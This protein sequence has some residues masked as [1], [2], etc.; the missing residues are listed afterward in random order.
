MEEKSYKEQLQKKNI[1]LKDIIRRKGTF[2][3]E[4]GAKI[5]WRSYVLKVKIEGIVMNFKLD[6]TFNDT[7]EEI[8]EEE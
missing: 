7:L 6:K 4:D 5:N 3:R 2:E 1:E 8:L